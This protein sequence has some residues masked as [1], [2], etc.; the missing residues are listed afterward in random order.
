MRRE[1]KLWIR[2]GQA[3][4]L[5]GGNLLGNTPQGCVRNAWLRDNGIEK[6]IDEVSK[7]TFALGRCCESVFAE[8]HP[9]LSINHRQDEMMDV[10]GCKLAVEF[11]ALDEENNLIYELKSVQSTEKIKTYLAAKEYSF[12]NLL[13]LCFSMA[14]FSIPNG[15]LR[16]TSLLRHSFDFQKQKFKIKQGDYCEHE[17]LMQDGRFLVDGKPVVITPNGIFRFVEFC[18]NAFTNAS[19]MKVLDVPRPVSPDDGKCAACFY[20]PHA[21]ACEEAE[22]SGIT[23][24]QF[25]DLAEANLS[26]SKVEPAEAL[27]PMSV[28][29][30]RDHL[31]M[32]G[33]LH[34]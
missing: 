32:K 4:C 20:C 6:P 3:G 1:P 24:E 16:Y 25:V 31:V 23:L 26:A 10:Y 9:E 12:D 7:M 29:E 17:V 13:Q 14:C 30:I 15:R 21:A 34:E 22:A 27:P 18:T 2:G 8:E 11:D 28:S 5:Q 19:T 33:L